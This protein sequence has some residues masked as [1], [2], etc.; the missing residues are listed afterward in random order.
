MEP[1]S[2]GLIISTFFAGVLMFL[3]P[4]TLPLIPAFLAYLSGTNEGLP[5]TPQRRWRLVR[6]TLA[7]CAGFSTVFIAL[8]VLAGQFGNW[9]VSYQTVLMQVGGGL[10]IA[11]GLTLLGVP[12]WFG[13]QRNTPVQLPIPKRVSLV[14]AYG[15]G[16]SFALAW[17]PCIGPV[18][19]TVLLYASTTSTAGTGA[20]LLGVFSLGLT[21]P[22]VLTALLYERSTRAF[23]RSAQFV[24]RLNQLAGGVLLIL[25]LLLL[26]DAMQYVYTAGYQLFAVLGLDTLYQFF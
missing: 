6:Y 16:V 20:F 19:A 1:I 2:S 23:I 3:A 17:T 24:A 15:I 26:F 21:I 7:Y 14:V 25:G 18:L 10:V 5:A 9:L 12:A 11:V 22:F 4:C 13:W 8:G